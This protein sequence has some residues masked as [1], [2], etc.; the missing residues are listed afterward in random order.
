MP[1]FIF[2]LTYNDRTVTDALELLPQVI[3]AGVCHIGFKDIGLPLAELHALADAIREA[4][5]TVYLEV[6]SLDAAS[7]AASAKAAVALGVDILMG[8]TRPE[9]ALPIIAGSGIGYYPF[10]GSVEGHPS[11]LCGSIDAIVT[12]AE[13]LI[14]L[15]GVHGL[16]LLAYRFSGD[17]PELIRR[18]CDVAGDKPVVVAGSI[19]TAPR[20]KTVLD[21]GATAFTVGTAAIDGRFP[22]D[23]ALAGQLKFITATLADWASDRNS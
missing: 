1:D 2:M 12:S 9:I 20:I 22:T 5:A 23:T 13:R 15:D 18:V 3:S 14:A 17:V 6:V 16:D 21:S 7:E 11:K 10:P 19:D 4:D 8:G